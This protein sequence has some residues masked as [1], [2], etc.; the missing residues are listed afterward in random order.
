MLNWLSLSPT[1]ET[2]ALFAL[3]NPAATRQSVLK[4]LELPPRV[5]G[6]ESEHSLRES[7][8]R[9]RESRE[10]DGHGGG[11]AQSIREFAVINNQCLVNTEN[12]SV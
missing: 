7:E 9:Y 10:E 4:Q 8:E 2:R 5:K 6:R 12:E 11:E 3:Q 1:S